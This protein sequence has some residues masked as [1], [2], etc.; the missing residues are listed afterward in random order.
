[1]VSAMI[2]PVLKPISNS[3]SC[4]ADELTMMKKISSAKDLELDQ[5]LIRVKDFE[6]EFIVHASTVYAV[7]LP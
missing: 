3:G 1:M 2:V 5:M 7:S 4:F 6:G